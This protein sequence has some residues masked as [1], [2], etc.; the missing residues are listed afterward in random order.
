M[1]ALGPMANG[2]GW[3]TKTPLLLTSL[4]FLATAA[5]GGAIAQ[6][7]P[8]NA[9]RPAAVA[10]VPTLAP[11]IYVN[12]AV[13]RNEAGAGTSESNAYRTITYALSQAKPGT[14]VQL[15]RGSYTTND[16]EV[17]PLVVPDGVILRGSEADKGQV[18]AIIG[19]GNFISRTFARQNVTILAGKST[20]IRGLLI[21]NPNT[22]G[23]G[24]WVESTDPKIENCTFTNN[25]REGV[26]VTG[27]GNPVIKNNV[28][29]K[30]KGN[31]VS[32]ANVAR[33][34]I[35][36]NVFQD[37][38]F[39]LAIGGDSAP[40]VASNRIIENVDGIYIN[41]RARP[42]LR[43]NVIENNTRDGIVATIVAKPDMGTSDSPGNNVI[44]NNG[45]FELNN[46]TPDTLY[47]YGNSISPDK[48]YSGKIEFVAP[49]NVAFQDVQGHW[50]QGYIEALVKQNVITGFPD[51][52]FRPS[53]PVT[54]AQFATIISKAFNPNQTQPGLEFRDVPRSFWGYQQIQSAV[55]GGFMKGYPEGTF[56][57]E[58]RIPRV[59]ALVALAT[60]LNYGA[61]NSG[62]LSAFQ[63]AG[64]IPNWAANAVA[65]STTRRVVVNYPTTALLNPNREATRAEVA[66]FVYQALV[67]AGRAQPIQSPY[68]VQAP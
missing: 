65:A 40:V 1:N 51:G 46:A 7:I 28:F 25:N 4:T 36:D 61:G 22:R 15:A 37:T 68:I 38:G 54:R 12:P 2:W 59:Q 62:A 57:P 16:G 21:T 47:S 44:R 6:S 20:E 34:E 43:S 32:V 23:T 41:D 66:A 14:V 29:A 5:S 8:L 9:E 17:F 39:G 56:Q 13:G 48:D 60:G 58:Q 11:I 42:V 3:L 24:I 27:T 26:F 19:G 64:Q 63:D 35:R 52:T 30:N 55:R 53:D 10:Q 31:G 33:G 18:T 50:A 67:D 45:K 49:G